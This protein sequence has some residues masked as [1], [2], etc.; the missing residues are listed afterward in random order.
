MKNLVMAL[1]MHCSAF[2]Y[3]RKKFP[4]LSA[5]KNKA[6]VFIGPQIIQL[7]KHDYF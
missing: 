2:A 7:F 4:R 6:G 1:G 3:L 5:E